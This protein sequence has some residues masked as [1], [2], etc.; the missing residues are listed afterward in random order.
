MSLIL[1]P[2][3]HISSSNRNIELS[4]KETSLIITDTKGKQTY[5]KISS[6]LVNIE[7]KNKI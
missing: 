5:D 3:T 6:Q 7:M 1:M 4:Q 2:E